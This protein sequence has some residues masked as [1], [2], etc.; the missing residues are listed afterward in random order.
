[1]EAMHAPD[2]HTYLDYRRYLREWFDWK[3]SDNPRYSHRLFARR[4]GQRSP[5]LL[6]LVMEGKR[7][8]TPQTTEAFAGAISMSE[9][10]ARFFRLLVRLDQ[11]TTSSERE[12]SLEAILATKRFREARRLDDAGVRYFSKWWFPAV[13]EL[14]HRADFRADPEWV[15]GRIQPPIAAADAQEALEALVELGLLE[16]DPNGV[17]RPTNR[18][19]VTPHEVADVAFNAYHAGMF[20]RATEAI[21]RFAPEER[22]LLGVTVAV[23]EGHVSE[24]KRRLNEVQRDLMSL[25]E[26][27]P[28]ERV[29]QL[30]IA[31]FPLSSSICEDE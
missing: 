15:A 16:P 28:R 10:E 30:S 5:S 12:E 23:P 8:L 1:M 4:A 14:A 9:A 18:S 7:N 3:K 25:C 27:D 29:Y 13:H 20:A 22:H 26:R 6:L 19:V 11:A 2:V 17:P 24:V 31:F 21:G